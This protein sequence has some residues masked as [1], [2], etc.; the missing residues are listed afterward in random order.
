MVHLDAGS[1]M[2]HRHVHFLGYSGLFARAYELI[3]HGAVTRR[4]TGDRDTVVSYSAMMMVK[5]WD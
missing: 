1:D 3:E 4:Y 5:F 2:C